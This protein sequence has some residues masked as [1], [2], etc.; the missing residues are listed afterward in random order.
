MT[1]DTRYDFYAPQDGEYRFRVIAT[2][3]AGNSGPA[4]EHTVIIDTAPPTG[5][6]QP[7]PALT[8]ATQ[9]T[10]LPEGL[11]EDM[12]SYELTYARVLEGQ[13]MSTLW[14]WS[15]LGSFNISQPYDLAVDDGYH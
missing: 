4:T 2:D 1:V 15:S 13:E 8:G 5:T 7:L 12:V 9:I 3:G 11:T 6:L 14:A 10:L